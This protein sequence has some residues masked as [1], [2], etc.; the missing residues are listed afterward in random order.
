MT[1]TG[2]G[3][4]RHQTHGQPPG[5]HEHQHHGH[6]LELF[7]NQ[8]HVLIHFLSFLLRI[9]VIAGDNIAVQDAVDNH[10]D[11]NVDA[12]ESISVEEFS[13]LLRHLRATF[14]T[15]IATNTG[16][17]QFKAEHSLRKLS[18]FLCNSLSKLETT[19]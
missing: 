2:R 6:R 8:H 3:P 16:V 19:S 12:L 18:S 4:I 14:A 1:A 15:E 11:V 7:R 10:V 9:V 5:K 17:D 13:R